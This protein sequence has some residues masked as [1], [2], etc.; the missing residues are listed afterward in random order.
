MFGFPWVLALLCLA[1]PA[2]QGGG[3]YSPPPQTA[4]AAPVHREVD[5]GARLFEANCASC[6]PNGG[7]IIDPSL[8]IRGSAKL[9]DFTRFLEFV[10]HPH[11]PNEAR[12]AMPAFSPAQLS[13]TQVRQIYLYIIRTLVGLPPK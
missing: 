9:A 2:C 11:M 5:P 3:A 1:L 4:T 10:R 12:G 8:P 6:H 7:N 13:D